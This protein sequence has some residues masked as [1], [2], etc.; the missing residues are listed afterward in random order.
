MINFY[1]SEISSLFVGQSEIDKVYIGSTLIFP[2]ST[3]DQGE[4]TDPYDPEDLQPNQDIIY[5]EE[6]GAPEVKTNANG[7][8][9]EFSYTEAS[10]S[11]PVVI[12]NDEVNTGFVPFEGN[13]D[14]ELTIKFTYKYTENLKKTAT[15]ISASQWSSG[16]LLSGFAV[17]LTNPTK[18]SG[19]YNYYKPTIV[20]HNGTKTNTYQMF[21]TNSGGAVF[22]EPLE[23][24]IHMT[25]VGTTMT[26]EWTAKT[27]RYNPTGTGT[28]GAT[29]KTNYT[30][31]KTWTDSSSSTVDILIGGQMNASGSVINTSNITVSEFSVREITS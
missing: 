23:C 25:K 21:I 4:S 20:V 30:V 17:R 22:T 13:K 29:T 16:Q 11:S 10:E 14:W 3:P 7:S 18:S 27:I 24:T 8:V 15:V 31:S 1:N 9:T 12:S 2:T 26:L 19:Q 5:V 6:P 28:S